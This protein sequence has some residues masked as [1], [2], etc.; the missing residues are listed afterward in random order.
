MGTTN[1]SSGKGANGAKNSPAIDPATQLQEIQKL[2]FGQQITQL[3]QAITALRDETRQHLQSF[4]KT[5]RNA[6][7]K[8]HKSFSDQLES[9]AAHV[10]SLNEQHGNREAVIEDDIE[11]VRQSIGLFEKQVDAAHNELET[12]LQQ[13]SAQLRDEMTAQHQQAMDGLQGNTQSLEKN[14]VDRQLLADLFSKV[15]ESI[16]N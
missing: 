12:S 1:T 5:I 6:L 2:L 8:Q 3:E 4:E 14:K 10:E 11:A 7:E 15:A 9:L 13:E 16:R